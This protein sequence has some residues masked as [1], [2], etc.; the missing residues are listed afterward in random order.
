MS[1][2]I[3]W[4]FY[5]YFLQSRQMD[6]ENWTTAVGEGVADALEVQDID[7]V[8][9][10]VQRYG[11]PETVTLR[12]FD[13]QGNL[14]ASSS[15]DTDQTVQNWLEVPG[16]KEALQNNVV[17]GRAKGVITADD[18]LYISQPLVRDGQLLGVI[19]MSITLQQLQRQFTKVILTILGAL[20]FTI[21]LCALISNQLASSLS[22]PVEQM[23]NFASR[24]GSGM[25]GDRLAIRQSNELDELALE[26]NRMSER[27]ASLDHERRAFLANVSHELRTPISNVYVTVDALQSGA[28]EEPELRDRFLQTIQD[29]TKRLSRLI[30]DLLDLGRLEAGVSML[31]QQIISLKTPI[32]R[33]VNAV[34]SRVKAA[35]ISIRVDVV[36]LRFKGDPERLV[37]A[38]LNILN[39]AIQHS[40]PGSTIMVTGFKERKHAMIQITDQGSGIRKKDLPRIFEQFY[41]TDPSRKGKGV[42]LGLAIAK[43]IIE[44]HGG[45][46]TVDSVVR[47]G[48]VFTICLPIRE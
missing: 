13:P 48:S 31:D 3:L 23:R 12:V 10:L 45:T 47:Q 26:L 2:Y 46:I 20:F 42:G 35:G 32:I 39:N 9:T 15:F 43:R 16:I 30:D 40:Q 28:V 11:A 4:S 17:R 14:L 8:Q 37:Q 25:F 24:V 21:L 36:P 41:T 5:T 44:A 6:L 22:K 18:R 34:E 1:G 38:I 27:L 29:E 7:R 19:R 33:A